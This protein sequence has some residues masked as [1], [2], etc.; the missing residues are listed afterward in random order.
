MLKKG[1]VVKRCSGGPEW[2]DNP[3]DNMFEGQYYTIR[4]RDSGGVRLEGCE[5]YYNESFFTLEFRPC[6]K[7][8]S[9]QTTVATKPECVEPTQG[10]VEIT[11]EEYDSLIDEINMLRELLAEAYKP[12]ANV[13]STAETVPTFKPIS[14]MTMEDW[15]QAQEEEWV[16]ETETRGSAT[17]CE[18][19]CDAIRLEA[20][21]SHW[22]VSVTGYDDDEY[23]YTVIKRIK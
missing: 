12:T 4:E 22:W 14:E 7:T 9:S 6:E 11:Q 17:V 5:G 20:S 18:V 19:D 8:L 2:F 1:D 13:D 23:G 16:F 10:L 3:A 21:L 15:K